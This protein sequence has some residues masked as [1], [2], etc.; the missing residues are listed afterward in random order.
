VG[1]WK[2]GDL[3][4]RKNRERVQVYLPGEVGGDSE[5]KKKRGKLAE[6]RKEQHK[7]EIRHKGIKDIS[8]ERTR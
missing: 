8:Q 4:K 1:N 5:K 7:G 6:N 3:G 2:Q